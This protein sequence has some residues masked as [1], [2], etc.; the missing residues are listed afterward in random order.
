MTGTRYFSFTT[1]T[2]VDYHTNIF[3]VIKT[4]IA[5]FKYV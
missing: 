5:A 3:N 2:N 4:K 1:L